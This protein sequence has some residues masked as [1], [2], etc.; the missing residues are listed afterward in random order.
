MRFFSESDLSE[1]ALILLASSSKSSTAGLLGGVKRRAKNRAIIRF[2]SRLKFEDISLTAMRHVMRHI[3]GVSVSN[4]DL[5]RWATPGRKA[6]DRVDIDHLLKNISSSTMEDARAQ[7]LMLDQEW[8]A[9]LV[10][11][12]AIISVS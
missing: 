7:M 11:A 5:L 9:L 8:K 10:R 2:C 12:R 1:V 6:D 3:F 4:D